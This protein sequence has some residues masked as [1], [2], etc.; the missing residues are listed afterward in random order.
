MRR[1]NTNWFTRSAKWA[2]RAAGRPSTFV[3]ALGIILA[4]LLS[5]PFF[6]FSDTLQLAINIGTTIIT[7][8]M[9]FLI[10]NTQNRDA[11]AL[12]IKMDELI[13][14]MKN[15]PTALLDLEE[16]ELDRSRQSYLKLAKQARAISAEARMIV[17]YP[18]YRN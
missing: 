15:A 4:W 7:F 12:Q 16:E 14:S 10:Q 9:V 11:E 6:N 13:R 8:L 18:N 1:K 2:S 3:I 17:G 5:G